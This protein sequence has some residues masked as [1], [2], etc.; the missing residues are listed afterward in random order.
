MLS[1]GSG[2]DDAVPARATLSE[3]VQRLGTFSWAAL[4]AILLAL[5]IARGISAL[6]GILAPLLIAVV[7]GAVFEPMM[8]AL[9]RLRL[10]ASAAAAITLLA[11]VTV[12]VGL[13]FVIFLGFTQQLPEIS[14]QLWESWR[15]LLATLRSSGLDASWMNQVR[16]SANHSLPQ[17]G[18]GLLGAFTSAFYG[19]VTFVVSTFLALFFLFFTLR[20][21]S[22]FPVWLAR[23]TGVRERIVIELDGIT[24]RSLRQYFKGVAVTAIITAPIFIVPLLLLRVP[25]LVPITILYFALSFIPYIGAWITGAFAVLVAFGSGGA[26][27]ALIVGASLMVSNGTVQSIVSSWALG[28]TLRLHPAAVLLATLVGGTVAGVLGMVLGPPLI[29][30]A[31]QAQGIVRAPRAN[32]RGRDGDPGPAPS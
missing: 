8:V 5:A 14:Q 30:I 18:F 15:R 12:A 9:R 11:A 20:D 10:P 29:A 1:F 22:V 32:G 4:G 27:A 19:L 28:A 2:N 13:G 25:L 31:R 26:F 17:L 23:R 7:L 3:R 6:G 16:E 24:R 21:S